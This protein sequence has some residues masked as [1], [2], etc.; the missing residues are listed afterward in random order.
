MLRK[1]GLEKLVMKYLG[2]AGRRLATNSP[3]SPTYCLGKHRAAGAITLLLLSQGLATAVP[4]G[5]AQPAPLL[6]PNALPGLTATPPTSPSK[7]SYGPTVLFASGK[8]LDKATLSR[9]RRDGETGGETEPGICLLS[10]TGL[11][12]Q[13]RFTCT[14][15]CTGSAK[16]GPLGTS[17]KGLSQTAGK[18]PHSQTASRST[19]AANTL[20]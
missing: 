12:P 10:L 1:R 8:R 6:P 20:I 16:G 7:T 17:W 5:S 3:P 19:P 9:G 18:P 15:V 4:T 13:Q 11:I 14:S 2:S